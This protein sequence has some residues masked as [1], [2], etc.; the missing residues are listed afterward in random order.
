MLWS[1]TV[2]PVFESALGQPNLLIDPVGFTPIG[3]ERPIE[4]RIVH[5]R[6]VQE[7]WIDQAPGF[8]DPCRREGGLRLHPFMLGIIC[9][10]ISR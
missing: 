2:N 3:A 6:H 8:F 4:G 5:Q 7:D 1:F 10:V 9:A